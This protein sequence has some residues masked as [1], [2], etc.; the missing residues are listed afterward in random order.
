MDDWRDDYKELQRQ[1]EAGEITEHEF[2][3]K[4]HALLVE[5]KELQRQLEAG[6]ITQQEFNN[7]TKRG[8]TC[9]ISFQSSKV[10]NLRWR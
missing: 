2:S 7:R 10:L 9:S 6:E 5:Y 3:R 1:L 8:I 4:A